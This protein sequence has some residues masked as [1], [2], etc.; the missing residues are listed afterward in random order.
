MRKIIT[1]LGRRPLP[2]Q[3]DFKGRLF[4]GRVFAEALRQFEDFDEML[5]CLTPEARE[6]AWPVLRDLDDARIKAVPIPRGET[7]EEMWQ[8]FDAILPHVAQGDEVIFDITHGLR[9]LPFLIFLFAAYLKTTRAVTIR[10]I[11]Y[12]AFELGD[13]K[14]NKPAPVID[15][16][17]FIAMLDWITAADRFM[18]FGDSQ[19]LAELVQKTGP[20]RA[21]HPLAAATGALDALSQSLRLIRPIDAMQISARLPAALDAALPAAQSSPAARP[22]AF[23]V[24]DLRRAYDAFAQAEPLEAAHLPQFLARLRDLVGWYVRHQQWVQAVSLAREWLITWVMW[25]LGEDDLMNQKLRESVAETMSQE[26]QR[27]K[28]AKEQKR[29]YQPL[30]LRDVPQIDGVLGD[31]LS[32]A[33]VRNDIDHAGMRRAPRPADELIKSIRSLC[34]KLQALPLERQQPAKAGPP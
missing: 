5:V 21:G 17:G 11:Y 15:L 28:E 1:F 4:S 30:F 2:T 24:G 27:R 10:A 16:S 14:Q 25:H 12:G 22:Y 34:T 29:S 9:S 26:A 23:L 7:T 8:M 3:Y 6:D 20:Y 31:W 33:G 32:L 19:D 18:R 13:S